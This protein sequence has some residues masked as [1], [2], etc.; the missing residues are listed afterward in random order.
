MKKKIEY[1]YKFLSKVRMTS[2][3]INLFYIKLFLIEM[4]SQN[5]SIKCIETPD[6]RG[7][8]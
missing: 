2:V 3:M 5:C 1:K 8:L 4:Y 7:S 6:K